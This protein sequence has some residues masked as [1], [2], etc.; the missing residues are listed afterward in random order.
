MREAVRDSEE[1]YIT[2]DVN[3]NILYLTGGNT[4]HS[5]TPHAV[6]MVIAAI[7]GAWLVLS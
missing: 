2:P 5:I 1:P 4:G 3:P 6:V 7:V